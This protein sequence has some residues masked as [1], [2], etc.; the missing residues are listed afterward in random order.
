MLSFKGL[1]FNA[2]YGFIGMVFAG[3]VHHFRGAQQALHG[4]WAAALVEDAAFR[5]ALGCLPGTWWLG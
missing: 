4:D 5:Q 1:A 3:M 2:A